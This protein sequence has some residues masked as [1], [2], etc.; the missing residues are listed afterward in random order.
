MAERGTRR[1]TI[2]FTDEQRELIRRE[3]GEDIAEWEVDILAGVSA[4]TPPETVD[5][6]P[7]RGSSS[8][9]TGS[10]RLSRKR[11]AARVITSGSKTGLSINMARRPRNIRGDTMTERHP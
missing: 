3:F 9:R 1:V 7:P 6:R 2:R 4:D 5:G 8:L 11:P 10:G